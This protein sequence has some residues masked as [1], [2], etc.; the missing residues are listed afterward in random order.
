MRFNEARKLI[1]FSKKIEA[2]VGDF[3]TIAGTEAINHF[4]LN[5]RK[6]GFDDDGV[7]KWQPRKRERK[8]DS[9]RA[10]LIKTGQL[11]RSLIKRKA[12]KS[13]VYIISSLP[14]A[15]RHNEGIKGMPKRQ[16][17]GDSRKLNR[18]ILRIMDKRIQRAFN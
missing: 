13:A 4:T 11:R 6:Q 7:K 17:V 9:G 1:E 16:F 12:D 14:Y 18:N 3:A 15:N 8:R 10:I 5:F 2:V